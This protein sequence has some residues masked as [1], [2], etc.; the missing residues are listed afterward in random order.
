MRDEE[1]SSGSFPPQKRGS[2][3]GKLRQEEQTDHLQ[4]QRGTYL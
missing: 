1:A 3:M 4:S 2:S